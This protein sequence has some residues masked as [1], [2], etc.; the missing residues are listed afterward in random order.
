MIDFFDGFHLVRK[1]FSYKTS[2][3]L[4]LSSLILLIFVETIIMK[5]WALPLLLSFV[6]TQ[7]LAAD[8]YLEGVSILGKKKTA[9][10]VVDGGKITAD[11]GEEL[12]VGGWILAKVDSRS[13]TLKN[14]QGTEQQVLELHQRASLGAPAVNP[15]A[16]A[17]QSLPQ[18]QPTTPPTEAPPGF[19]K[20]RTP[21]GE[22]L[23]K[24]EPS[25]QGTGPVVN[26]TTTTVPATAT[27]NPAATTTTTA[28]PNAANGTQQKDF[29]TMLKEA[30]EKQKQSGVAP[31]PI[32]NNPFFN[33]NN[34]AANATNNANT[35]TTK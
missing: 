2:P 19:R 34:G 1:Y 16:P 15:A 35:T 17:A 24:D 8:L 23:V 26:P 9:M 10:L 25:T 32:T 20:V 22:I 33:P 28:T 3:Y 30:S 31:T 18:A 21:F 14:A 12:G 13:V 11:E 6:S 4:R 5:K 29:M 27:S 7:V